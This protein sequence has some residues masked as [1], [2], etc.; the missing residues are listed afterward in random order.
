MSFVA[1]GAKAPPGIRIAAFPFFAGLSETGRTLL[2]DSLQI[3]R[4]DAGLELLDEGALC[5]A[6]LLVESGG[7]RV[8]K[9][10]PGGREITL[11][12]VEP[13]ESCVLGTS[14]V[15][16]D[17]RYPAHAVCLRD[18]DALAV[19]AAVFRT[20]YETEAPVRAFVMELFSRRLADMMMLVE[21]VAFRRM[22]ERL[23]VFL[24]E[25]GVLSPGVMKP[26]EMSHGEIAAH[27]G[28]ARE[29]VSRVLQQFADDDLVRLE[30][31]KVIIVNSLE[32]QTRTGQT[33]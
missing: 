9:I 30:R 8:F 13:G 24:L 33:S 15:V 7:I 17:L 19:P 23:A 21:E 6:L 11:Y 12:L 32:L 2:L 18:T 14:C 26:I 5:Q 20:L 3:M 29:V 25:Q 27:L 28:T 16:N 31:K 10:S 1:A 4:I 22:D